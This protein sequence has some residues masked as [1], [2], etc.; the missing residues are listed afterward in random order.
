MEFKFNVAVTNLGKIKKANLK[1]NRLT[2]FAGPNNTGKSYVSRFIYSFFASLN[3]DP[4][5]AYLR[6]TQ[7]ELASDR[8]RIS[9][10]EYVVNKL[11][12]ELPL[13]A[14]NKS[15]TQKKMVHFSHRRHIFWAVQQLDAAINEI[16]G[17]GSFDKLD[18]L[19]VEVIT[20]LHKQLILAEG[21]LNKRKKEVTNTASSKT[22]NEELGYLGDVIS[23]Y[24]AVSSR[25]GNIFRWIIQCLEKVIKYQQFAIDDNLLKDVYENQLSNSLQQNF[26]TNKLAR[27]IGA[28]NKAGVKV[29]ISLPG[30]PSSKISCSISAKGKVSLEYKKDSILLYLLRAKFSR[31]VY[32]ESPIYWKLEKPL[33]DAANPQ[34]HFVGDDKSKVLTG[35]PGYFTDLESAMKY[36]R[37]GSPEI[38]FNVE[39]IIGGSIERNDDNILV[40]KEKKSGKEHE[41]HLAATGI[42]QLGF[43]SHLVE[44]QVIKKDSVVFIDEPEVHLHPAWQKVMMEALCNLMEQGVNIIFA[45]HSA[46]NIQWLQTELSRKS[47]I[48]NNLDLNHFKKNGTVKTDESALAICDNILEELTESFAVEYLRSL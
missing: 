41:L 1:F 4:Q 21:K 6:N 14:H 28:D 16:T 12:V 30:K 11:K 20:P 18:K 32:L 38:S 13:P 10:I 9:A 19:I 27:L 2:V 7:R 3:I 8:E 31:V 26:Q 25:P 47:E 43:I 45:S 42:V 23:E 22:S 39:K 46:D 35:V 29:E 48:K 24:L 36:P 15:N 17:S 44:T 33:N 34:L 5:A 37:T 40:Y